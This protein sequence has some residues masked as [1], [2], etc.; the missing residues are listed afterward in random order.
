MKTISIIT[1]CF[2]EEANVEELYRRIRA[3][4]VKLGNYRYEHLFIDNCSQ[5]KTVAILKRIATHD[6]NVKVIVNSRN[7]RP[8]PFANARVSSDS[9]R[10]VSLASSPTSRTRRS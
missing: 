7:S 10:L 6:H 2:D 4:M 5:D 3:E 1:P 9:G 8:H